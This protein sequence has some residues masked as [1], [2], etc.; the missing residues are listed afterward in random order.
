MTETSPEEQEQRAAEFARK[1][2]HYL[3]T[4]SAA[5]ASGDIAGAK[6]LRE[7]AAN[8]KQTE[9]GLR[10]QAARLRRSASAH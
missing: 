4:A 1:I 2:D 5:Q 9:S 8:Y 6:Y 7:T 3:R 10:T